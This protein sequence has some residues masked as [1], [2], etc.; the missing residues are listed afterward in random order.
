VLGEVGGRVRR[1]PPHPCRCSLC[2][3][4]VVAAQQLLASYL[5]RVTYKVRL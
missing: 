4:H 1:A 5:P 2:L 3:T